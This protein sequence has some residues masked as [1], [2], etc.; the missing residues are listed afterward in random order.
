MYHLRF[1]ATKEQAKISDAAISILVR[2]SEGS[3]R[4]AMSLMD[5]AISNHSAETTAEEVREM[6]GLADRSRVLDLFSLIMQG[7]ASSALNELSS[8]YADGADP[9]IIIKELAEITH[10]ISVVKISPNTADDPT[11]TNDERDRGLKFSTSLSMRSLTR[12]WQ[13]LLKILDEISFAPN[14]MIAAE[15]AII[16]L[17]HVSELPSPDE[18]IKKIEKESLSIEQ[19]NNEKK[20]V[21]KV[22]HTSHK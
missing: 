20:R 16:R 7:N 9:I 18:I 5:Q 19:R 4:D 1:I 6:I 13:M 2:A 11:V 21:R 8:Q 12:M 14:A 3:V 10:W 17:T 15:M 22:T